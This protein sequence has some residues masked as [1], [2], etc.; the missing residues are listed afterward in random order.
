[1]RKSMEKSDESAGA[2]NA[3]ETLCWAE[4]TSAFGLT[5]QTGYAEM[6]SLIII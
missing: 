5:G 4:E 3:G 6:A 2:E 1:M